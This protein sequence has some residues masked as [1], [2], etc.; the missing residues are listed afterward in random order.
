VLYR[1]KTSRPGNL[2]PGFCASSLTYMYV[3]VYYIHKFLY[4]T[5]ITIFVVKL[6]QRLCGWKVSPSWYNVQVQSV[7]KQLILLGTTL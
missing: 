4:L 3:R 2:A 6:N 5:K 1:T 7:K